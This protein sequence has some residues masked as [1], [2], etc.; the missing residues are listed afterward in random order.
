VVWQGEKL[1]KGQVFDEKAL[2]GGEKCLRTA[3]LLSYL[4]LVDAVLLPV[5]CFLGGVL[6]DVVGEIGEIGEGRKGGEKK[7]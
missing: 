4:V 7:N 6:E 2:L 5:I 1:K 3:G